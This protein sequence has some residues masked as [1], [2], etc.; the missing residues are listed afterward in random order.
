R[1]TRRGAVFTRRWTC[2]IQRQKRCANALHSSI[3]IGPTYLDTWL[4]VPM[5]LLRQAVVD[6][7]GFGIGHCRML[8]APSRG[9]EPTPPEMSISTRPQQV[10]C[11]TRR[12]MISSELPNKL[13]HRNLP[14]I[15]RKSVV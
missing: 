15:D 12:A 4:P 1:D 11:R 10:L 2:R 13:F 7:I 9:R 6:T 8:M 5:A 14:L 3:C